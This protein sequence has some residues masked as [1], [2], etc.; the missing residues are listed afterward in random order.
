MHKIRNTRHK[1]ILESMCGITP[2]GYS[3]PI[4]KKK[5]RRLLQWNKWDKEKVLKLIRDDE[6]WYGFCND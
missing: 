1:Q 5:I 4:S 2:L 3:G 6:W